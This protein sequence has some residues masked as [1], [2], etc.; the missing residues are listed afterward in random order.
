MV[1]HGALVPT[2]STWFAVGTVLD[3]ENLKL[4]CFADGRRLWKDYGEWRRIHVVEGGRPVEKSA[5][6]MSTFA[7]CYKGC[8]TPDNRRLVVAGLYGLRG[9][10]GTGLT[11]EGRKLLRLR[12]ATG[13]ALRN[14]L[15]VPTFRFRRC[16][17]R[18][19]PR[20]PGFSN[21]ASVFAIDVSRDG[22]YA[23]AAGS[24]D[25]V[26][27]GARLCC[28]RIRGNCSCTSCRRCRLPDH[29]PPKRTPTGRGPRGNSHRPITHVATNRTPPFP[30]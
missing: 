30:A 14:R 8:L 29:Q 25:G 22:R 23:L 16:H 17:R 2:V 11:A 15:R 6:V 3:T 18:P 9:P 5:A 28:R 4:E 19:P 27:V 24:G 21:G 1:V 26:R 7:W 20:R 10:S 12:T 13:R